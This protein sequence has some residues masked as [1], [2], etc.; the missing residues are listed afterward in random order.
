[1]RPVLD[2]AFTPERRAILGMC[3]APMAVADLASALGLPLGVVRIILD[4]LVHDGLIEVQV[5]APRGGMIDKSVLE[6][7]LEGIRALLFRTPRGACLLAGATLPAQPNDLY[8]PKI[9]FSRPI[10]RFRIR[11]RQ[12]VVV[13]AL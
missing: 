13:A 9:R 1:M 5:P 6:R 2:G 10:A 7:V 11:S 8:S 4:D 12:G 3:E